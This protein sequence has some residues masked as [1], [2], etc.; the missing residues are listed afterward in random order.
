[1]EVIEA[2]RRKRAVRRYRSDPL[3]DEVIRRILYAGRR[4]QSSKNSQP[5]RFIVVRNRDTLKAL[6]EL[7]DF[8]SHLTSAAMAVCILTPDPATR[9]SVMFDAGQAAA[10]MQLE[11][12]ELG[13]GSCL[14]TLHRPEPA[15]AILGF[16]DDLHLHVLV[17]FGYPAD[18]EAAFAPAHRPGGRQPLEQV[19]HFERWGGRH[20]AGEVA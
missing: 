8:A 14:I 6:S 9:W 3:P 13:V 15:R 1:M 18:P 20:E 4:A 12:V 11:G 10:Y 2:I 7:G 19:V 16:P 17:A 5:W